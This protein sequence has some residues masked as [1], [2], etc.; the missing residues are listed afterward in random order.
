MQRLKYTD[1][2][3]TRTFAEHLA[4]LVAGG[5]EPGIFAACDA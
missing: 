5:A 4:A 3:G 1:E 2:D